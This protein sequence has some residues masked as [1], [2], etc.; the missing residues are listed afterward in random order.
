MDFITD[1]MVEAAVRGWFKKDATWDD[2]VPEG[3]MAIYKED[4]RAALVA[5]MRAAWRP[6]ESAPKDGTTVFVHV[7]GESRY[8]TAAQ[9]SSREYFEEQ[10]GA[11]E[12]MDE[13]WYWAFGYPSDFHEDTIEPTHWQPL[14]PPPAKEGV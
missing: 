5:A 6:I 12:Y 8:P 11:P 7:P 10:Y 13:G 1:E 3:D 9:F 2:R 14:P 4:M